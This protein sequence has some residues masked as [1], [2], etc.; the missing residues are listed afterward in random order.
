MA[1]L[2]RTTLSPT[3][4]ELLT[5]WLPTRTWFQGDG[6]IE[7]VAGFR[8]DDPDGEVGI[9][10]MLVRFGDGPVHH[11]PLTYRGAPLPGADGFLVATAEHGVL[12]RRWVYDGCGDPV[13]AAALV[14][15]ILADAGQAEEYVEVDGRRENRAPTM[16][17]AGSGR[18]DVPAVAEVRRV[19]D[20]DPTIVVTDTVELS[21]VRRLGDAESDLPAL[22]GTWDGRTKLL[23]H[24]RISD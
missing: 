3:K 24:A 14:R 8:F 9:E 19:E 2:H 7:R 10:T 22:R 17:I 13:Y 16:T 1:L 6:E 20:G 21:V 5:A 11:V 23:A 4:L 15:A 12:G 18:T